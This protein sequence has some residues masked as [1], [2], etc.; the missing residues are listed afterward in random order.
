MKVVEC[1]KCRSRLFRLEGRFEVKEKY[2]WIVGEVYA[3]CPEC[4]YRMPIFSNFFRFIIL[5]FEFHP[6]SFIR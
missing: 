2:G 4:G 5:I 3:V 6:F 1:P